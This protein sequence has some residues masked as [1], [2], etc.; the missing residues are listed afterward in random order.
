M[1]GLLAPKYMLLHLKL[2]SVY[3]PP[4]SRLGNRVQFTG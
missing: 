4:F 3:L 1:A 2:H